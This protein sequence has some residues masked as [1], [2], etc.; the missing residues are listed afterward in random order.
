[1]NAAKKPKA[2]RISSTSTLI[3]S[4]KLIASVCN[5]MEVRISN[6]IK[7]PVRESTQPHLMKHI[8]I[9]RFLFQ[10]NQKIGTRKMSVYFGVT[11]FV[12]THLCFQM[13]DSTVCRQGHIHS[14]HLFNSIFGELFVLS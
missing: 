5:A 8:F 13:S 6:K 1:M 7:L 3:L 10:R 9:L 2:Y 12:V 14:F 4:S 11:C